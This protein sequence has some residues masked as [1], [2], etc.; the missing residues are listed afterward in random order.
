MA[1][2]HA[3]RRTEVLRVAD[4]LRAVIERFVATTAP[5]GVFDGV[6]DDLEA[7]ASR[8]AQFPQE[9]LFFGF[10]EA[11]NAGGME[12]PFDYSPIMGLAN[13]LAPP[14]QLVLRDD[15]VT[16]TVVCGSA[17]EGPP[18]HVH[19]GYVAAMFDEL[20][21][22][23]QSLSGSPGMTARLVVNYRA[24]TPLHAE[25]R[26]EGRLVSVEGRKITC[27]GELYAGEQ[28]C[29]EAEG[30]FISIQG[31]RFQELLEAREAAARPAESG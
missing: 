21:G 17:Y 19:G 28:L 10:P 16:G 4:A 6:A 22:Y 3:V 20:L 26:A 5:V 2:D 24:P 9:H 14:M 27:V 11:A 13:P 25:L 23:T 8:L 29:A 7:I 18:G 12:G 15:A 30:L 1:D 31:E